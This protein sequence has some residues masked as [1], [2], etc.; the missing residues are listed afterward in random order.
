[1]AELKLILF[2]D[3][4]LFI[5]CCPLEDI[6]WSEWKAIEQIDLVVCR[7]VQREIDQ[8]KSHGRSR[9]ARQ[10][11]K[12]YSRFRQITESGAEYQL[13]RNSGPIVKLYLE[14]PGLPSTDLSEWLDY[15]R[16]D[17][18]IIGH[19]HRYRRD[20]PHEDVRL[21]THDGGPMMT[22]RH[23]GLPFISIRDNW[24]LEAEHSEVERENERLKQRVAQLER[25]E[26][27]IHIGFVDHKGSEL[28]L[29]ELEFQVYEPLS[30]ADLDDLVQQLSKRFP[31]RDDFGASEPFEEQFNEGAAGLIGMK[32]VF[33]PATEEA[34]TK[35]T[36]EAYPGWLSNC[37]EFLSTLHTA[38]QA[39]DG[40]PHFTFAISNEGTRPAT[41]ALIRISASGN[42]RICPP[43][44]RNE[45]EPEKAQELVLPSPPVPPKGSFK[46]TTAAIES[47]SRL[48]ATGNSAGILGGFATQLP[49]LFEPEAFYPP[50][51]LATNAR[52]PN[53][54]YY[55]PARL[56]Q[57]DESFALECEQW[58]HQTGLEH[59]QGHLFFDVDARE[60]RGA[61]TCEV[62]AGNLSVPA[63][64]KIPVR[65]YIKK[66]DV[67][68]YAQEL[69]QKLIDSDV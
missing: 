16:P 30:Y 50:R 34:I 14:G 17:D 19:L 54:F 27:R 36:H 42:F 43:M 26:P 1:M 59:F 64:K 56:S 37:K 4:N 65:I 53:G 63:V 22:A 51:N 23:L 68:E 40:Q 2:P 33:T 60:I 13:I 49:K 48:L 44:Y 62:H 46:T 66:A 39:D 10:A 15:S 47:M 25:T 11:Q 58:R 52:D 35:Y 28:E 57:P 7:T 3:T 8:Q 38:L 18:E 20:H 5:E 32:R 67:R 24:L 55:K 21:L 6:D 31:M 69:V 9:I 12:A 29:L 45:N 61:L 41:E